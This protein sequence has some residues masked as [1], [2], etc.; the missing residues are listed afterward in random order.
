MAGYINL[1]RKFAL[2]DTE[3]DNDSEGTRNIFG[4]EP[5]KQVSWDDLLKKN[6]IV[7][8]AEPGTGKTVEFEAITECLRNEGKPAFF[9]RKEG[10]N[11]NSSS[12]TSGALT[13]SAA[14]GFRTPSGR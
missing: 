12:M 9:C 5:G 10:T 8:L 4:I 2:F 6:R 1:D 14:N 13:P 7:I 11:T 3:V